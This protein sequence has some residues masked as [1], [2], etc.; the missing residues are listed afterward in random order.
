VNDTVHRIIGSSR[1][2]VEIRQ[3][4]TA[5][6]TDGP[7]IAGLPVQAIKFTVDQGARNV[8]AGEGLDMSIGRQCYDAAVTAMG[9]VANGTDW[10]PGTYLVTVEGRHSSSAYVARLGEHRE[11]NLKTAKAPD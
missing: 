5:H 10:A 8:P 7:A 11:F 2:T 6:A 4:G 9:A 3:Y 1:Y